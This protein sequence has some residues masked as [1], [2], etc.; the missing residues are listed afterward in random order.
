MLNYLNGVDTEIGKIVSKRKAKKKIEARKKAYQVKKQ[1]QLQTN[2]IQRAN[3]LNKAIKKGA[4]AKKLSP[5][6][7]TRIKKQAVIDLNRKT[8]EE[9]GEPLVSEL[10]L[11]I[12]ESANDKFD[13]GLE[14]IQEPENLNPDEA[15]S[16]EGGEE[17]GNIKNRLK[18][19]KAKFK[20]KTKNLGQ[21][22]RKYTPIIALARG[23]FLTL[24]KFN[25]FKLRNKIAEGYSKNPNKIKNWWVGTWG[26][27]LKVL[28]KNL[29]KSNI[30]Q[31]G[32]L[33][34]IATALVSSAGVLVS[35][36]EVLKSMNI[37][38]DKK[39]NPQGEEEQTPVEDSAD[40]GF[41]YPE[42][43][44]VTKK[45]KKTKKPK[46]PKKATTPKKKGD[47]LNKFVDGSNK[48]QKIL[49]I[50]KQATDK[51]FKG[52]KPVQAQIDL[53]EIKN[54][55]TKPKLDN[56]LLIFGGIGAVALYLLMKKK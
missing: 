24:L 22:V 6:A 14:E 35:L 51:I 40:L 26:G 7:V 20:E 27:D 48:L 54:E 25:V 52:K 53:Q 11:P 39:A 31:I 43:T 34:T 18:K 36:I 23:S 46:E 4:L 10:P 12:M 29:K 56:K 15:D 8:F 44:G 5:L 28:L 19:S 33:A 45:P 50:T 21:K 49:N 2:Q 13:E 3:I 32:E 16:D 1:A 41:Y 30:G 55:E 17:I 38:V 42:F 47:N 37:K 9:Q